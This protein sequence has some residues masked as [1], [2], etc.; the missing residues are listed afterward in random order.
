MS[1]NGDSNEAQRNQR[2]QQSNTL[3]DENAF[4]TS[5]K[6]G[7]LHKVMIMF[8]AC[9]F[10]SQIIKGAA[11]VRR[12]LARAA[13]VRCRPFGCTVTCTVGMVGPKTRRQGKA[14]ESP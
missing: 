8:L 4:E 1:L 6:R 3:I 5:P 12:I 14:E 13:S 11:L 7:F 2:G 10:A 9:F